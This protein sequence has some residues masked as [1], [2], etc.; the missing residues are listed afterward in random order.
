MNRPWYI[1][2]IAITCAF[3][4]SSLSA[5]SLRDTIQNS[6]PELLDSIAE[7]SNEVIDTDLEATHTNVTKD[8]T[9][10]YLHSDTTNINSIEENT[11]QYKKIKEG[12]DYSTEKTEH[13]TNFKLPK[14]RVNEGITK[15]VAI[16]IILL[17][18]LFIIYRLFKNTRTNKKLVNT[19]NPQINLLD[20][21]S[22]NLEK[23]DLD[24]LLT[25]VLLNK[26]YKAAVRIYYLQ[27]LK[28]MCAKNIL[29]WKKEK[30]NGDYLT[31][32]WGSEW[33]EHLKNCTYMYEKCWYG[34][35]ILDELSFEEASNLF[36]K[37]LTRLAN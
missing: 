32:S 10:Y 28:Q 6:R 17:V 27:I 24:S 34:N 20:D 35:S 22:E 21:A 23:T 5:L 18:V 16:S 26:D 19:V 25:S 14:L 31:E 8:T 30:T 1:L 15:T 11:E 29:Q 37:T 36:K 33:F 12:L 4:Y 13:K 3:F 7:Y 2:T 9:T